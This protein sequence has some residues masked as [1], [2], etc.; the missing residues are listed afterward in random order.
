VCVCV[1]V[2]VC[3]LETERSRGSQMALDLACWLRNELSHLQDAVTTHGYK[4]IYIGNYYLYT[5]LLFA[6]NSAPTGRSYNTWR[7]FFIHI[8]NYYL[9]TKLLFAK[10]SRTYRTQLRRQTGTNI[11]KVLYIVTFIW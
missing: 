1:C 10:S 11:S 4:K 8:G 5:K 9:H 3:I 7:E 6:T 2:C